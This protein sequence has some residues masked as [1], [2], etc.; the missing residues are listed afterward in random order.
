MRLHCDKSTVKLL[1]IY[2]I[3]IFSNVFG[4]DRYI[5]Y[6]WGDVDR[7]HLRDEFPQQPIMYYNQCTMKLLVFWSNYIFPPS[8]WWDVCQ[9]WAVD[10]AHLGGA[11]WTTH[12]WRKIR[13]HGFILKRPI[14]IIFKYQGFYCIFV[15]V[16]VQNN[17][18]AIYQYHWV[19]LLSKNS[20][21]TAFLLQCIYDGLSGNWR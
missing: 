21:F 11:R 15:T 12:N 5:F 7:P 14:K 3:Y 9:V 2:S 19:K 6:V 1:F 20:N 4:D 10:R 16:W 13:F 18:V 8:C 17:F